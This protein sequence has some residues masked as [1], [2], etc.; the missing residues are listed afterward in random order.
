MSQLLLVIFA[1][2]LLDAAVLAS[3]NYLPWWTKGATD[4]ERMVRTSAT[5]LE[6][7]YTLV[8][9][10]NNG[11]PPVVLGGNADGG[12]SV[13]FSSVLPLA[14]AS[15]EG[16][17]WSYGQHPIDGSAYSGLNYFCMS[18][19]ARLSQA[20]YQGIMRAKAVFGTSQAIFSDTC[21]STVETRSDDG[22][23][24]RGALTLYVNYIPGV[25]P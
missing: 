24:S 8:T 12:L 9:R 22:R 21:G 4:T 25:T 13:N 1:F 16:F 15:P 2:L 23:P 5:N 14:P 10:A 17:A 11:T 7:A 3:I 20:H 19:P 6:Q 18:N